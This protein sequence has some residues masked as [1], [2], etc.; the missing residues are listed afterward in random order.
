MGK[1]LFI[2]I[3]LFLL[4]S[5]LYEDKGNYDYN[6]LPDLEIWGV[7]ENYGDR[8][9]YT[10]YL[11]IVPEIKFS[12]EKDEAYSYAWYKKGKDKELVLISETKDLNY[13]PE[14][15]GRNDFRFVVVHKETGLK[16]WVDTYCNVY[17]CRY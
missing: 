6:R 16:A 15:F 14:D 12:D 7:E 2:F 11:K 5:C 4:S 17:S 8:L 1:I 9:L 10:E 3:S 13:L